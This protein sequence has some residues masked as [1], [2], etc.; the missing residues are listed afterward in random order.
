MDWE[1]NGV[2]LIAA[3]HPAA[4][5]RNGGLLN[6]F[7]ADLER[8]EA[9]M[10]GKAT[11]VALKVQVAR[12]DTLDKLRKLGTLAGPLISVDIETSGFDYLHDRVL[13]I[14]IG[15]ENKAVVINGDLLYGNTA[16][17]AVALLNDLFRDRKG[18]LHN[19]NFD[20]KF[21]RNLGV[22]T[23]TVAHDTML[24]S[25]VLD[26]RRGVHGL[27]ELAK[28]YCRA[29]EY[30]Q[31][32]RTYLPSRA[33]SFSVIPKEVLFKYAALDAY[34]TSQLLPLLQ[35]KLDP[36]LEQLYT[37]I[38]LPSQRTLLLMEERGIYV[39]KDYAVRL[40][41][42][43]AEQVKSLE[44]EITDLAIKEVENQLAGQLV[45]GDTP[46]EGADYLNTRLRDLKADGLN[47]RSP[48]QV[49]AALNDAG[50]SVTSSRREVLDELESHPLV[51]RILQ[52]RHYSKMTSTYI[53]G[54][55]D[56]LDENDRVHPSY[57]LHGT[58]TGR[59]AAQGPPIQTIPREAEVRNVFAAPPGWRLL[60]SD[61]SMHELRVA[62]YYSRSKELIEV[63][64]DPVRDVHT[65]TQRALF[66]GRD[67]IG[68]IEARMVAKMYN[69][70]LLYGRGPY[71]IAR[72]LGITVTE[73]Q[74]HISSFFSRWP[75]LL[76]WMEKVRADALRTGIVE[77]IFGRRRRF[78]LVTR[79]NAYEVIKQA[80]NMLIQSTAS[81]ITLIALNRLTDLLDPEV[82]FP[83]TIQHDANIFQVRNERL[84]ETARTVKQVMES[85]PAELLN[86]REVIFKTKTEIGRNWGSLKPL[87]E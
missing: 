38:L 46:N 71:S 64:N 30:D 10:Q 69:F 63:L 4:V 11:T 44:A 32:L 39:D 28:T 42:W 56:L 61:Y 34:Y 23:I 3:Y 79:D 24:L 72:Q 20:L 62:A 58:V 85:T 57:L 45:A 1:Y 70:G 18:V 76:E 66:P 14:S 31:E 81:D 83:V 22:T 6:D 73:A 36:T 12:V 7:V 82:A 49:M 13:C 55:L 29:P 67:Y 2:P 75:G 68:G 74:S 53:D 48:Q 37:D 54:V 27:K 52:C 16:A 86:E 80:P 40:R 25:Y 21:L 8:L 77:T 60:A 26:E 51:K 41:G 17:E 19:A 9:V 65:E 78:G 59:L 15:W 43:Y 35:E 33:T 84:F 5:I 87:N 47:P 50:F